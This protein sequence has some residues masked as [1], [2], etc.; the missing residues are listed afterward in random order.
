[1]C[2]HHV[3]C[4]FYSLKSYN[5]IKGIKVDDCNSCPSF[6]LPL[7]VA[8]FYFYFYVFL[9]ICLRQCMCVYI[10]AQW[11]FPPI[12]LLVVLHSLAKTSRRTTPLCEKINKQSSAGVLGRSNFHRSDGEMYLLWSC[13][14]LF[15]KSA[16]SALKRLSKQTPL[17]SRDFKK[18]H[19]I[20]FWYTCYLSAGSICVFRV[21]KNQWGQICGTYCNQRIF[22]CIN[23]EETKITHIIT[24]S[25][26]I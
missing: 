21:N 23:S 22:L 25:C 5:W 12:H 18:P 24:L 8:P 1:M 19:T 16:P 15:S 9:Q 6:H 17:L 3:N 7:S 2:C 13:G 10:C 14:S 26:S 20:V 11:A 4:C